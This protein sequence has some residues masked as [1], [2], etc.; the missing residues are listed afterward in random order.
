MPYICRRCQK[1]YCAK[2]RL[3]EFH[4]CVGMLETKGVEAIGAGRGGSG[5]ALQSQ[6]IVKPDRREDREGVEYRVEYSYSGGPG[7]NA[8]YAKRGGRAHFSR[9]EVGHLLIALALLVLLSFSV[10]FPLFPLL[11]PSQFDPTLFVFLTLILFLSFLPHELMHKVIAQRHGLFAEFRI[12][13]SYALL[14]LMIL[15]VSPFKI[16]APGAVMIGGYASP[17]EYGKAAAAGPATN[18]VISGILFL[19]AFIFPYYA[20]FFLFG[21][22]LSGWLGFFNMI[23]VSPFDGEKVLHWSRAAF[24]V[25]LIGCLAMFLSSVIL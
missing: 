8:P 2:H 22:M 10:F 15:L 13:P 25:L 11:S 16:Y 14:T 3:P 6:D 20:T 17:R 19:F 23:P 24:A 1:Q 21:A 5:L 18:L 12:V 9:T 7:F 4:D